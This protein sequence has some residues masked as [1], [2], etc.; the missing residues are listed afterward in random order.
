MRCFERN[1]GWIVLA[2]AMW[3]VACEGNIAGGPSGPGGGADTGNS[4]GPKADG[5]SNGNSSGGPVT[6]ASDAQVFGAP[7]RR[8]SN[9]EYL[10]TLRDLFPSARVTLP[11]LPADTT[12]GGF[13]ND[14][15]SLGASEVQVARWED[16]AW[17]YGEAV[18]S[19]ARTLASF[20]PCAG[21][22][23][24]AD[25]ERRCGEEF[26]RDFGLR[27]MRRPLENDEAERYEAFFEEQRREIDFRAAVQLTAMAML[28][29]PSF[30]YR[31]E[32]PE[33]S[34]SGLD[35]FEIAT[36]LSYFL[37]ET[38]PDA[39]LL[40]AALARELEAPE[41]IEAHARRML[42]DPRA[43]AAVTD[44]H[45]QWLNFDRILEPEHARRVP[46]NFPNWNATLRASVR[47]E[48]DR[49]VESTLFDGEGTLT[50]LLTSRR[51]WVN[52]T[53]AA[54]YGVEGPN[55][56]GT[57]I[58]VEL[59]EG[60][61]SGLLTRAGFLASHS[62]AANGSPPLRGVFITERLLCEASPSPPPDAN[63]S[64]PTAAP[65][66]EPRTNRELFEE[67][68]APALCQG[69]H[70]RMDGFGFG[71]ENYDAIG[72]F[73]DLDNGLAVDA[74][75]NVLGTDVDGPYVGGVELSRILAESER[76][77]SCAT[78]NWVR[79]ALGRAPERT[80]SCFIGRLA[81]GF[82]ETGGNVRELLVSIVT[83]PEFRHRPAAQE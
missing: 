53:L 22:A 33:T 48:Q 40:E 83:S 63:L 64:P 49:F 75:G 41:K 4:A 26:I 58:E 67:R 69:C 37:W 9:T 50:A 15:S 14:A 44:F 82:A 73:R 3:M 65:G 29:S 23:T 19:D 68:T 79:Y 8:L 38:T 78:R 55:N 17:R 24:T 10:N 20:L 35:S 30:L 70:I 21:S 28:Q 80:D 60:E 42:E 7:M 12:S 36:R 72:A 61:R 47:E 54:L 11:E 52:R 46:E 1:A 27:V 56:D 25:G 39:T 2:S 6:C 66:S 34:S 32:I 45:R 57:W 76:V 16:I 77:Q 59:P 13:E 74:S 5:V 51:T 81:D 18:T 31:L 62:H 71:F 43:R